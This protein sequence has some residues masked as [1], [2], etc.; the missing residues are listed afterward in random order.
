VFESDGIRLTQSLA[1]IEHLEEIRPVPPLLL[2]SPLTRAAIRELALDVVADIHPIG[3][4]RV[5]DKLR[6]EFE[7]DAAVGGKRYRKSY[8][9]QSSPRSDRERAPLVVAH[10][11]CGRRCITKSR[12]RP[13]RRKQDRPTDRGDESALR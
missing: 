11:V 12:S 5:L 13:T 8:R 1:I 2:G 10:L 9:F 3:N 6:A 4:L 7:A